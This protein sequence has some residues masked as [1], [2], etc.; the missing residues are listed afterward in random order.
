M[1]EPFSDG[2]EVGDQEPCPCGSEERY[3]D[4]CKSDL[5]SLVRLPDGTIIDRRPLPQEAKDALEGAQLVF[6]ET[7]GRKPQK[8]DRVFSVAHLDADNEILRTMLTFS[9]EIGR[10]ELAYGY[11]ETGLIP[12]EDT[13]PKLSR[14]DRDDWNE[15]I[16]EYFGLKE[17]GIDPFTGL[18]FS[19]RELLDVL[20]QFR[21]DCAVH[22][23]SYV[24]RH[25]RNRHLDI[26]EFSQVLV[27]SRAQKILLLLKDKLGAFPRADALILI[28]A[29]FETYFV[30]Q[31][32]E[33]GRA[34]GMYFLARASTKDGTAFRYRRS[35][36][37]KVD[38]SRVV[39]VE[40]GEEYPSYISFY[41]MAEMSPHTSDRIIFDKIYARLSD[42]VHFSYQ[43]WH[44][45]WLD[46][47]VT[48]TT[49]DAK[50][51]EVSALFLLSIA[52]LSDA[53]SRSSSQTQIVRRDAKFLFRRSRQ[54]LLFLLG[55]LE[56]APSDLF[57]DEN[58]LKEIV[59]RL[60]HKAAA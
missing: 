10:P 14:R 6:Q 34:A 32:L 45:Y 58:L 39:Y 26:H 36:T 2:V 42:E 9:D 30:F 28:R 21:S 40:T 37:G 33:S 20:E 7:F 38:R 15:A 27:L 23:G 4:C 41:S 35:S 57:Y 3:K 11:R 31:F 43:N 12:T 59:S 19:V 29:I 46:D 48:K 60:R 51:A 8:G 22:F 53:V 25:R 55:N 1:Q 56:E 44:E 52:L 18:L 16:D 24:D 54:A 5:G 47:A 50:P 17:C 13:Y 49:T